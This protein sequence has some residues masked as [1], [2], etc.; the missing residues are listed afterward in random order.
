M[1]GK[2]QTYNMLQSFFLGRKCAKS[3]NKTKIFIPKCKNVYKCLSPFSG[4]EISTKTHISYSHKHC[5][6]SFLHQSKRSWISLITGYLI[7]RHLWFVWQ[8]FFVNCIPFFASFILELP[9]LCCR[10]AWTNFSLANQLY[11]MFT[12]TFLLASKGNTIFSNP[13]LCQNFVCRSVVIWG[14]G[15]PGSYMRLK[16]V[17]I[18]SFFSLKAAIEWQK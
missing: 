14:N 10:K 4:K 7:K 1:I 9:L 6:S 2:S 17:H 5:T 15:T 11:T 3:F 8:C 16:K 18:C 12:A 13:N